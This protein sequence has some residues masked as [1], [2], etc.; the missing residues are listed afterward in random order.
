MTG[1]F[2]GKTKEEAVFFY[3][4]M[5]VIGICLVIEELHQRLQR[6]PVT[7]IFIVSTVFH[8]LKK[9]L[10]DPTADQIW[11]YSKQFFDDRNL[12][13][14]FKLDDKD[15]ILSVKEIHELLQKYIQDKYGKKDPSRSEKMQ[16]LQRL[17]T[18]INS[19]DFKDDLRHYTY[20]EAL[21]KES[22]NLEDKYND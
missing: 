20:K 4:S 19:P 3:G 8:S 2:E 15:R 10:F 18:M 12:K 5:L 6:S 1:G 13:R 14:H 11:K 21:R 7:V 16:I 9:L 17:N 22:K